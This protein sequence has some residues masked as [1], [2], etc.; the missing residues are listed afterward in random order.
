MMATTPKLRPVVKTHGGKCYLARRIVE[1]LPPHDGYHEPFAGGLSVLLNKPKAPFEIASDKDKELMNVY[2][3]LKEQPDA[4]TARLRAIPYSPQSF[5]WS[6]E[7][8]GVDDSLIR[9]TAYVVRSRMSRGGLGKTFAWSER[10]RGGQPGD[11]NGWQTILAQLPLIAERLRDV[12]FHTSHWVYGLPECDDDID[13][14]VYLDPPYMPETRTA[15]NVFTHEMSAADHAELLNA[16]LK[17]DSKVAISGYHCGLYDTALA[18]WRVHEFDMPNHSGQGET[19]ERRL[20]CL[21]V[22]P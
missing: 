4:L 19:K 21:W 12:V 10:L 3:V 9:A 13:T 18:G 1:V 22:K 11:V 8:D 20:E 7:M 2:W 15:T 6:C 14:L 17:L 16:V 5:E